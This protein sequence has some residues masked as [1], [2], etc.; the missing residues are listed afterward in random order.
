MPNSG[1]GHRLWAVDGR[2]FAALR[3]FELA[4]AGRGPTGPLALGG[5][6]SGWADTVRRTG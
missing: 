6:P 1:W 5:L 4:P 2:L 3:R